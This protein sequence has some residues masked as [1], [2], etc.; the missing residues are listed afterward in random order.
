M[1]I[2]RLSGLHGFFEILYQWYGYAMRCLPPTFGIYV[3]IFIDDIV[4]KLF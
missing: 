4:A 3:F 1:Q 2:K